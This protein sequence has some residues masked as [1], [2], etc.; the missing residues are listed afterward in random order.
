MRVIKLNKLL[1]G[2]IIMACFTVSALAAL[3]VGAAKYIVR[4]HEKKNELKVVEPKE[5]KFGSE[6]KVSKKLGY[7]E[8]ALW[9]G[10][11]VLAGEHLIHGEVS[12]FPPF[13][14]AVSE[15]PDAVRE[16]LTEMGT[17]GVAMLLTIVAAWG[18]GVFLVDLIKYRRHKKAEAKAL[19]AK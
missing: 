6:V 10:S 16:M 3:G 7:L 9:A 18:I 1:E 14:T 19:E 4:H 17:V 13:L 5:Y 8:L 12:P 11:F 2:D 15:G